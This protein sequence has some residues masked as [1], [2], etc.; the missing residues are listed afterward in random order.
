M[1]YIL[2]GQGAYDRS[3]AEPHRSVEQ[4]MSDEAFQKLEEVQDVIADA[5]SAASRNRMSM[6][7]SYALDAR[8]L[9]DKFIAA[10]SGRTA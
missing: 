1:S 5:L 2:P 6:S 8:D 4:E 10:T 7:N 3:R 9:L